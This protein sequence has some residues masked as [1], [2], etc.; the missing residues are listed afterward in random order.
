MWEWLKDNYLP[1]AASVQVLTL[2]VW[3]LYFEVFLTG[4]RHRRRPNILVN[5]GGGHTLDAICVVSNMSEEPLYIQAVLTTLKTDPDQAEYA[6]VV[7]S[8]SDLEVQAPADS[9]RRAV[10]L[11]GSLGSGEMLELGSFRGIAQMV[12]QNRRVTSI[13]ASV[14]A[15]DEITVTVLASYTADRRM[16][17]AE[18]SFNVEE[19]EGQ[20]LLY[21]KSLPTRQI[22]S[23]RR[24]QYYERLLEKDLRNAAARKAEKKERRLRALR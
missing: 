16:V 2:I 23:R 24:I 14:Q 17:A 1:L 8:L 13:Q 5:S 19:F 11:Q 21:A 15:L 9:D 7:C 3:T 22:S 18:R 10:L 6:E 12:V 20:Q 4:Y